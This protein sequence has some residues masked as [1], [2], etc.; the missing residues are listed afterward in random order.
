MDS[1]QSLFWTMVLIFA[2][3]YAVAVVITQL[4]SDHKIA[5]GKESMEA[6]EGRPGHV[7]AL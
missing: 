4:V 5:V 3:L 7:F 1:L 6:S 2:C